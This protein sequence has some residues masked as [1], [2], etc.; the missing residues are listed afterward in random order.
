MEHLS[1]HLGMD[2]WTA[3]LITLPQAIDQVRLVSGGADAEAN[4][5]AMTRSGQLQF[6]FGLMLVVPFVLSHLI[7]W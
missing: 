2:L 1:S 5:R 3:V 4:N 7:G 6:E